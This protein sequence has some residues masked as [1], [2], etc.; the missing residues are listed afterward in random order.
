MH[1][2]EYRTRNDEFRRALPLLLFRTSTSIVWSHVPERLLPST[3]LVRY[4]IFGIS[5]AYQ[6][7]LG[8]FLMA[9]ARAVV[10]E[11]VR[12]RP[13]RQDRR[14]AELEWDDIRRGNETA[15]MPKHG[16]RQSVSPVDN[17][18]YSLR[19]TAVRFLR[20]FRTP[21]RHKPPRAIRLRVEG[22]GIQGGGGGS[23]GGSGSWPTMY[24]A[25]A[26]CGPAP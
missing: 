25:P 8:T 9:P 22:S 1:C 20:H 19:P 11:F 2:I 10:I 21:S 4:S 26:C 12:P 14:A 15:S 3:F 18:S 13:L 17:E 5:L 6:W 23:G 24:T 7:L 16:G